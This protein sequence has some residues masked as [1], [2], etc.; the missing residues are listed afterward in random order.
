MMVIF[1]L[2]PI[3]NRFGTT[4]KLAPVWYLLMIVGSGLL[5]AAVARYFSEPMNRKLRTK[6]RAVEAPAAAVA[7][8]AD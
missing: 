3:A 1:A 8:T 7:A 6:V 4:G 2:L 5:G